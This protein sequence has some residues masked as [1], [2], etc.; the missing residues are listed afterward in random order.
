MITATSI[1]S[2]YIDLYTCLREYIWSTDAV[3]AIANLEVECYETFPDINS[4]KSCLNK[5]RNIIRYEVLDEDI[6]NSM[7]NFT[8]FLNSDDTVYANLKSFKE[9]KIINEDNEE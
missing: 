7:D 8:E 2:K 4:I 9:V 3:E 5:L 1:Q 6:D